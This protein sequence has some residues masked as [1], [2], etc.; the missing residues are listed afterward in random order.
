MPL[1][2]FIQNL[3]NLIAIQEVVIG[4]YVAVYNDEIAIELCL[5]L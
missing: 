1:L 4:S 2:S 3:I 5:V